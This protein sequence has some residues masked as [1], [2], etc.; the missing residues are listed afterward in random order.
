MRGDDGI[1]FSNEKFYSDFL[2]M[3]VVIHR[4][5]MQLIFSKCN[6]AM[7]NPVPFVNMVG[8]ADEEFFYFIRDES[9]GIHPLNDFV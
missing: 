8:I 6:P 1:K 3:K 4:M 9:K 5:R 2:R 7:I